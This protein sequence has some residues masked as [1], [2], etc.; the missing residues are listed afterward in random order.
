MKSNIKSN[1]SNGLKLSL[2]ASVICI[3]L[4]ITACTDKEVVVKNIDENAADTV[5]VQEAAEPLE[6]ETEENAD[7][8][9]SAF[10][11]KSNKVKDELIK[12]EVEESTEI[13]DGV[14]NEILLTDIKMISGDSFSAVDKSGKRITVKLT[15]IEAPK[16]GE[17]LGQE[18]ADRLRTCIEIDTALILVQADHAT[19]KEG[20]TLA[21]LESEPHHCNL[22]QI[23]NGMAWMYEGENDNVSDELHP[24]Y[25]EAH[26]Y[27]QDNKMG[28]WAL[29]V[30]KP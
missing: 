4:I 23:E 1:F 7:K 5:L 12:A 8:T 20:R 15:G 28:V 30:T 6:V 10:N 29:Y 27:A 22:S 16:I 13:D 24:V 25:K 19:D 2:S 9:V 26:D 14:I 21:T 3:S 18:S 11:E 17:P